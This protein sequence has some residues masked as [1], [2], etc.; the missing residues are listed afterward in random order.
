M[1]KNH[2]SG[3]KVKVRPMSQSELRYEAEREA[4]D[5]EIETIQAS[6]FLDSPGSRNQGSSEEPA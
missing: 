1:P 6:A 3:K 4:L 5:D 2:S